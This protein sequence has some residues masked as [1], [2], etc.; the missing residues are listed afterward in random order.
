MK[1]Y[2]CEWIIRPLDIWQLNDILS[3]VEAHDCEMRL[4]YLGGFS[5]TTTP[6]FQQQLAFSAPTSEKFAELK[7]HLE[8]KLDVFDCEI[9]TE[10]TFDAVWKLDWARNKDVFIEGTQLWGEKNNS[11]KN[12]N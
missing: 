9:I 7:S 11:Q 2:C 8:G 6:L 10:E 4:V 12:V 3:L 1:Y 5:G